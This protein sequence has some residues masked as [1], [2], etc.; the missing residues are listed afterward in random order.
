VIIRPAR[1][2]DAP[3]ILA[4]QNPIIRD[5][6]VTFTSVEKTE[7]DIIA[8]ITAAPCFLV[9]EDDVGRIAGFVSYDQLR[10]GPGYAR[11]M[12]HSIILAPEAR[13]KGTG[14]LLIEATL[15]HAHCR[16]VGS[17]WAGVSGENPAGLAFHARA[18]FEEVA[19]L[20]SV[21]FKFG[22][23]MDLILMRKWLGDAG[24]ASD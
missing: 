20:P 17:M 6:A 16:G 22:R 10:K 18:G 21:G 11:S 13:G 19:R 12:E 4:I 9:A 15:D 23:W 8:A 3:A 5:T 14:R 24:D 7:A 2:E 1:E